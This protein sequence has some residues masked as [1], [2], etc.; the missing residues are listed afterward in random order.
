MLLIFA[1]CLAAPRHLMKYYEVLLC[2]PGRIKQLMGSEDQF[3]KVKLWTFKHKFVFCSSPA[4]NCGLNQFIYLFI[5]SIVTGKRSK[6][7]L[8]VGLDQ[9][10]TSCKFWAADIELSSKKCTKSSSCAFQASS[11]YL[12]VTR[13]VSAETA[14]QHVVKKNQTHVCTWAKNQNYST[15]LKSELCA[16]VCQYA[17]FTQTNEKTTQFLAPPIL[18]THE[19]VW[20]N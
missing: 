1:Y 13:A 16:L 18:Y 10:Q 17:C 8:P 7:T 4:F 2:H 3:M 11:E 15:L 6:V 12:A 9:T 5:H 19:L 20:T 14:M